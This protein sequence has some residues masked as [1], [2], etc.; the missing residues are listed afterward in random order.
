MHREEWIPHDQTLTQE[1]SAQ[2]LLLPAYALIACL[3]RYN[4]SAEEI[5]RYGRNVTDAGEVRPEHQT[6]CPYRVL[7]V[8]FNS[9]LLQS[10][11]SLLRITDIVKVS[12]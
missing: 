6:G 11:V 1:T 7:D 12:K 4:Y 9:V 10:V 8:R 2:A 5:L 3:R